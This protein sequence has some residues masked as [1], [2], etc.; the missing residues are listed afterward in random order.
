MRLGLRMGVVWRR[1]G[2]EP[3]TER[4]GNCGTIL[5]AILEGTSQGNEKTR[6]R[7]IEKIPSSP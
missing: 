1:P 4:Y 2:N 6:D 3:L 5:L 7:E